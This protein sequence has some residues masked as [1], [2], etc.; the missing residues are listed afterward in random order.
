M[1]ELVIENQWIW[2]SVM[3]RYKS[4]REAHL[5]FDS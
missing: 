5:M 4:Q 1:M 3:R 2:E